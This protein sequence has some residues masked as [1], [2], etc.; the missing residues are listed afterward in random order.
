MMIGRH[1]AAA[2]LL[3]GLVIAVIAVGYAWPQSETA[4]AAQPMDGE[5]VERTTVCPAPRT[6]GDGREAVTAFVDPTAPSSTGYIAGGANGVQPL[7]APG[8]A[9]RVEPEPSRGAIS[10]TATGDAVGSTASVREYLDPAE[11]GRGLALAS[12]VPA[13]A[14]WWFVGV[15]GLPGAIDELLLANPTDSPAVV[16]VAMLGP[17]GPIELVGSGVVVQPG[18]QEIVR[19][20]SLIPG[21][22]AAALHVRTSGGVIAAALRSTAIDGLIPLGA[23]YIPAA[24]PPA[25]QHVVPGVPAGAGPRELVLVAGDQDAAVE[26]EYVTPAGDQESQEA[27]IPVPAQHVVVVDIADGLGGA[28]ASVRVAANH[29]VT[30]GVRITEEATLPADATGVLNRV[31]VA[32]YAW[33]AAQEPLEDR[34][35]LPLSGVAAAPGTVAITSSGE[36]VTVRITRRA[37]DGS[38]DRQDLAVPAGAIR[39]VAVPATQ[40]SAAL[41][42]VERLSGAG[43]WH[44]A[45][46]QRGALAERPIIAAALGTDPSARVRIPPVQPVPQ[47]LAGTR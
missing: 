32:D 21:V 8:Q 44:A 3:I 29:P 23:E 12:C 26:I 41:I 36:A 9:L 24:A 42:T 46:T 11:E 39:E 17:A 6:T 27:P 33:S 4:A 28:A 31:P 38:S 37:A 22:S 1:A 14:D 13:R 34:A 43:P 35:L 18:E 30:A 10:I 45:V 5:V 7:P 20:D 25:L 40:G 16:A 2:V 19:M 47:A 15:S